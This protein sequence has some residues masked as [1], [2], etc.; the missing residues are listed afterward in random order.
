MTESHLEEHERKRAK[1]EERSKAALVPA[2]LPPRLSDPFH[3]HNHAISVIEDSRPPVEQIAD[4]VAPLRAKPYEQQLRE[5]HQWAVRA[6][7]SALRPW[8]A[9]D[10]GHPSCQL[11]R[12]SRSVAASSFSFPSGGHCQTDGRRNETVCRG[13]TP[14]VL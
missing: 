3:S 10:R 6:A 1:A 14:P 7:A 12:P 13:Q 8:M 9:L 4:R 5:K 2:P 11:E